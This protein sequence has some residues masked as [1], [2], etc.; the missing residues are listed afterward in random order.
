MLEIRGKPL[1]LDD[2]CAVFGVTRMTIYKWV[3][4]GRFPKPYRPGKRRVFWHP[5]DIE[6]T[7]LTRGAA[8]G[9]G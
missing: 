1:T 5:A 4:A 2:V 8:A 6:R 9:K 7:L 3:K